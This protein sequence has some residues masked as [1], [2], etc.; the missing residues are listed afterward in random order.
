MTFEKMRESI[1]MAENC[2]FPRVTK[3]VG[4]G[5]KRASANAR[6][7]VVAALVELLARTGQLCGKNSTVLEMHSAQVRGMYSRWHW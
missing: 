3:G 5:C 4:V 6:A 2:S 7:A 1:W